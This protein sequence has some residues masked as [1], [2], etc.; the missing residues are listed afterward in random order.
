MSILNMALLFVG[1]LGT[2]VFYR[3]LVA[4]PISAG[5]ALVRFY[6]LPAEHRQGRVLQEVSK[7]WWSIV[8]VPFY[9]LV[10]LVLIGVLGGGQ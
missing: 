7:T 5:R 10:A 6:Q 9:A 8:L 3:D 4:N 1:L 2:A